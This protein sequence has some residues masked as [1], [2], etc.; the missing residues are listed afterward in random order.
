M[1]VKKR[2][3]GQRRKRV[4]GRE[5]KRD[6]VNGKGAIGTDAGEEKRGGRK[7]GGR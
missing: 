6:R 2:E 4:S 3:E 1:L 5:S 7:E